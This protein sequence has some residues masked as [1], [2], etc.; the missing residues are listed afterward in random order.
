MIRRAFTLIELLVVIAI[1][2]ILAAILFPVFAQAKAAAKTA[3]DLS[4]AK[5]HVLATLMYATDYDDNTPR[6]DNNGHAYFMSV[7]DARTPDWGN[8]TPNASNPTELPM[9]MN[10]IQPYVKNWQMV[11]GTQVGKTNWPTVVANQASYGVVMQTPYSA[12]KEP[13]YYGVNG[14]Y[15]ANILVVDVW[16]ARGSLGAVQRPAE[17]LLL[18][19]SVWGTGAETQV[20]LGNTGVW[21]NKVNTWNA[22]G[23]PATMSNCFDWGQGW[24]WYPHRSSAK[25][26]SYKNVVSGLTTAGFIDG[27]VKAVNY[28]SLERC[29]FN[30]AAG[31]W[32][33]THWDYRY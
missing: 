5:Q 21:P 11:Y 33:Y 10:V 9:F 17:I 29:D 31:L 6:L 1:I 2:A 19:E 14:Y 4:N 30:S 28:N 12:A 22:N 20:V 27:H 24:T 8:D 23:S 18:A 13:G 25:G 15:A 32:A 3:S 26:G 7:P 16:G